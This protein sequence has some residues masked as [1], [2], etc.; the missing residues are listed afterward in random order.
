MAE[1]VGG[2]AARRTLTIA[3]VYNGISFTYPQ[4][5][6]HV[7]GPVKDPSGTDQTL[8]EIRLRVRSLLNVALLPA[9]VSSGDTSAAGILARVRHMLT[10]P[11]ADLY[12]DLNSLPGGPFPANGADPIINIPAGRDDGTGPWPDVDAFRA[13]YTTPDTIEVSWGC[14]V[15]LLDCALGNP[16]APLSLRWEDSISWDETWKATYRRSGTCII[17]SR[18][19]N[20]IDDY[21][22]NTISPPVAPG[23]RRKTADY[24]CSRDGLRCDFVFVDE[25]IRYAPPYPA[26]RM[27]LTQSETFPMIGGM[28]NGEVFV[29]LVGIQNADVIDLA[30]WAIAITKARIWAANPLN[31]EGKVLGNTVVQTDESD[32]GVSV[33]C[34]STYKVT[35]TGAQQKEAGGGSFWR[36]AGAGGAIGAGVGTIIPG[37][38]TVFGGI[39]GALIGGGVSILRGPDNAPPTQQGQDPSKTPFFPWIGAG[40]TPANANN[41]GGWAGWADPGGQVVGPADGVG[42]A[43]AVGIFAA[44]L[45]DPCGAALYANPNAFVSAVTLRTQV[46]IYNT[47]AGGQG[48]AASVSTAQLTATLSTFNAAQYPQTAVNTQQTGLHTW[49]G[50]PGV[51]DYWQCLNEYHEDP[52]VIVMP[53]CNPDGKNIKVRHSSEMIFLRKRFAACRTGAQ[54]NLPPRDLG[55]DNWVFTGGTANLREMQVAPDGVSIRYEVEGVYEYYA[56]D[57]SLVDKTAEIAPFLSPTA[58]ANASKWFGG[59]V[60][61]SGGATGGGGDPTSF[62]GTGGILG[63]NSVIWPVP[64]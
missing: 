52:G 25:Q 39:A 20:K 37:V 61:L 42:L 29:G 43:P 28:K 54:P 64:Q 59:T 41:P 10:Q 9:S 15:R 6:T 40:T 2:R 62:T 50:E 36:G 30:R 11:R 1:T 4:T 47:D 32:D 31:A 56:L 44:V 38:G 5:Q 26:V 3:L 35:P 22:R 14:S 18:D 33:N 7:M 63:G 16:D 12:Y 46:P 21:R 34:S 45:N 57:P 19:V 17:S 23:F 13:E 60:E 24:T 51:Y 53:T 48:G 49:D 8:T 55:D 58:L 27:R